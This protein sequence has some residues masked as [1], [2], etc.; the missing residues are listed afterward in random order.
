MFLVIGT[1][2][3]NGEKVLFLEVDVLEPTTTLLTAGKSATEVDNER[4]FIC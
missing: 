2:V 3:L 4:L 1:I